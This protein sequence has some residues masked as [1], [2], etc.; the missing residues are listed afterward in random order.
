MHELHRRLHLEQRLPVDHLGQPDLVLAPL[1]PA[2]QHLPLGVGT[3]VAEARAEEEAVELRLRQGVRALVLDR[4]LRRQDEEGALERPRDAVGRHL[5]LLHRLEQ[6]SLRLRGSAVDLVGEQEVRE[7]RA[8]AEVEVA[9]ALVPDRG[10]RHVGGQEVGR[11]LDAAEVE[12]AR[13]CEGPRCERLREPGHVLE[14]HMAVG[15]EAEQDQLEL[16][17]LADDGALDLVQ[18]A[19]APLGQLVELH[20]IRSRA[21]TTAP[22]LGLA[23]P[24]GMPLRSGPADRA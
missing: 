12:P 11:E 22:G 4:V 23:D 7:D 5:S 21:L 3:R 17:P 24:G 14:E 13:L 18:Q 19:G 16:L 2:G 6:R 1:D 15:E 8:G 20:Q 9:V 10:P